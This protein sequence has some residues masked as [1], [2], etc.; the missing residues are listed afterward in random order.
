ML[1]DEAVF[2]VFDFE[3]TGLFPGTGDRICEIGAVRFSVNSRTGITFHSMVNPLRSISPGAFRVNRITG[4]MLKDAPVIGDILPGF[5]KFIKGT[6]LVAYNAGFDV[7]FLHASLGEDSHLLNDH[8]II[9]ALA[10][11][12]RLYPGF[13]RYSLSSVAESLDI[14]ALTEHRAL[15]DAL[16]TAKVFRKELKALRAGGVVRVEDI[17][18]FRSPYHPILK[19]GDY[20][21]SV[22]EEAI[23][24]EPVLS[25]SV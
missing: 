9:D 19:V 15:A 12:R 22:I 10:I 6:V 4:R 20:D 11:A 23:R 1:I 16:T 13:R 2:T 5:V 3:T 24:Q 8:Y 17:E 7:G 14:S 18:P 25:Q 21:N